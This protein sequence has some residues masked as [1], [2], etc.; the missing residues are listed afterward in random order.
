M[1]N[2]NHRLFKRS[3]E[4]I[5]SLTLLIIFLFC[6]VCVARVPQKNKQS[7]RNEKYEFRIFEKPDKTYGY[8]ISIENKLIIHQ[9]SIPGIEGTHGFIIK[10]DAVKIAKLVIKK[11][12]SG[13]FPPT[14]FDEEIKK[15]KIKTI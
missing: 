12:D 7:G 15:L 3:Y 9:I 4:N 14:I 8:D 6:D 5:C 11:L 13:L 1:I 10:K 2:L